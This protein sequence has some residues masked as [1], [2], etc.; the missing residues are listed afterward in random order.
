M[1]IYALCGAA[2]LALLLALSCQSAE[3]R[4]RRYS[5]SSSLWP[6]QVRNSKPVRWVLGD[7]NTD[8]EE[9]N[10][11]APLVQT[12]GLGGPSPPHTPGT[13]RRFPKSTA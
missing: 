9:E 12:R 10:M 7:S 11:E 4:K 2:L 1:V 8:S 6:G 3:A 13:A 5:S